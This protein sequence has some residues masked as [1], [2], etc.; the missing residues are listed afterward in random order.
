ESGACGPVWLE[1]RELAENL[2]L[3]ARRDPGAGVRHVHGD[4][5]ALLAARPRVTRG[6]PQGDAP[7]RRR[8]LDGVG[9]QVA[10]DLTHAA[11]VRGDGLERGRRHDLDIEAGGPRLR[12]VLLA[13]L[14]RDDAHVCGFPHDLGLAG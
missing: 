13:Q 12:T 7:A 1:P 6:D 3:L 8:V 2:L 10:E 14:V 5:A 11:G 9:D 4:P